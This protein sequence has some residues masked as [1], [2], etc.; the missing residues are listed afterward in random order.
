MITYEQARQIMALE[1]KYSGHPMA[2]FCRHP[3]TWY[4]GA[5]AIAR[6][7]GLHHG[8]PERILDI[9]SGFGYFVKACGDLGHTIY[10]LDVPEPVIDEA[11]E[12]LG[13][14]GTLHEINAFERLSG[15]VGDFHLITTFGVNFKRDSGLYWG[16]SPYVF[17]ADDVRSRLR[18]GGRWVLR[19]NQTDDK[20]SPIARLMEADWWRTVAGPQVTI[21]VSTH[22]VEIRWH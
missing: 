1:S 21:T 4:A 20:T 15:I 7:M 2:K 13:I 9:G 22:E 17:L 16:P 5:D 19:P 18:P 3:E 12:I 6:S 8:L 10:G 11:M 14:K